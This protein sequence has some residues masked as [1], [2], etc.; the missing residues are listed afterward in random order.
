MKNTVL[1]TA[2]LLSF[3]AF[4]TVAAHAQWSAN[5][6]L[7]SYTSVPWTFTT[8][9]LAQINTFGYTVSGGGTATSG[10]FTI[11]APAIVGNGEP[12]PWVTVVFDPTT[13]GTYYG[14][15]QFSYTFYTLSVSVS[16]TYE[17]T[18]VFYPA[19]QVV[20]IIYAPPGNKSQDGFT[21]T[22]TNGTTTTI[23]SSFA[24]GTSITF[25]EG[26]G[27]CT[28]ACGSASE[29]F[30]TS[31]TTSSSTAFQETFTD[32]TGVANASEP[33]N[34]DAINHNMDQFLIWLDPQV[35]VVGV[36][37]TPASYSVSV[38][39][40]ANGKTP[41]PDILPI[42][43]NV[44]EANAAGVST[45]PD[46]WLNQQ[47]NPATGEYT[48][49]LAK[50]CKNLKTAEYDAKACTL[51][52]QC[53][54]TPTD[55][56]PILAQDPLLYYNGTS[57]P[58]SPYP[59]YVSPLNANTSTSTASDAGCDTIPTPAGSDCRYVPVPD[60]VVGGV[61]STTQ[62]T[63][64]LPGPDAPGD[65]NSP[66]MFM[67][68]ENDTTTKTLG[69]TD[70]TT[71]SLSIG[72]GVPGFTLT[73]TNT[74]TWTSMQSLGTASGTGVMQTVTLNS[75]TVLCGQTI[76]IYEDTV[77]HTFVFQQPGPTGDQAASC[78]T[79]T[80]TPTFSPAPGTY[81]TEQTV[82]I[83]STTVGATIYYTT[84]GTAPTTSSTKYTDPITVSSTE[85]VKAISFF[86]G[87]KASSA[88][89]AVY[90]IE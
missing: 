60:S 23:G 2:V 57:K 29:S 84:N 6:N 83:S 62:K 48:P 82:T 18:S 15:A 22:T 69:S 38:Q 46:T 90:T 42:T 20:S 75:G 14:S 68:G 35:T 55:F 7:G 51:L 59:G 86:S 53:G 19:Y 63:V 27:D 58:P 74:W 67:Q 47:L 34:P 33:T 50:I 32:A 1:K 3:V 5:C 70:T 85:T 21:D 31:V 9:C 88:G 4:L 39:P 61:Q 44:M 10:A 66:D 56:A 54:C 43:A 30:G 25:T 41:N 65:N 73:G 16:A 78:T 24:D 79:A 28:I 8:G 64:N 36:P 89:S 80:A 52:D 76:A 40:T 81:T 13:Y 49:G 11:T 37:P 87:W 26:F 17:A 45:V 72:G 12:T 71:V 77:Y